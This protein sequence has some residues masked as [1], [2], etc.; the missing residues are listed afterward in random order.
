VTVMRLR[1]RAESSGRFQT[2]SKSTSS[3]SAANLGA[4]SPIA[5]LDLPQFRVGLHYEE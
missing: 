5:R 2:S 4:M 1:S 3:V